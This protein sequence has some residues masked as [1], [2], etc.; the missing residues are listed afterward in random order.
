MDKG[1]HFFNCDFQVH[2]PRDRQWQGA[3]PSTLNEK[4][5][6]AREFVEACRRKGVSAVA[7]ADHHDMSFV[8]LIRE[9][10]KNEN[11]KDG[12][13][14]AEHQ[15]LVVFPGM[16]LT[17]GIPCQALIIF[18]AEL[19]TD[20][21]PLAL[22]A[23]AIT[24]APDD[25]PRTAET[26]RLDD[27]KSLRQLYLLMD[28]H[29]FLR[30]R[31]I[32]LPNV[33]EGGTST[34]LRSGHAG[35]YKEMP[36]VGGYVDGEI[37]QLGDGNRGIIG[38]KNP[39]YGNKKIAVFQ[40]S[41][42]RTRDFAQ[43]GTPTTW[44]KWATPT[45]EALRQ[46]CLAQE[47]RITHTQPYIPPIEI[48]SVQVSNSK[49]LG[50]VVIEFNPQYNAIIGGRGTG[51][52]TILEYL[53]WGLCDEPPADYLEGDNSDY[54]SKRRSLIEK[55]L[56]S[57]GGTVQTS[58][59]LNGVPHIVRRNA[60]TSELLL[61]IG[62]AN[63]TPCKESDVRSLLPIQ[64]YSQKQ[65]SQVGVKLEELNRF[66]RQGMKSEL[67]AL[68]KALSTSVT[69]IRS[70]FSRVLHK[71]QI[72][73]R[74][75]DNQT[76]LRSLEEQVRKLRAGL[77][78]LD[79]AD[80]K[81]ISLQSSYEEADDY[82]SR[83]TGGIG[84]AYQGLSEITIQKPDFAE[85][86][87]TSF[88]D[89]P[90]RKLVVA[91]ADGVQN[92]LRTAH[93]HLSALQFELNRLSDPAD[94]I[95]QSISKWQQAKEAY[96]QRYEASKTKS[97]AQQT[98]LDQLA[99][100]EN[101]LKTLRSEIVTLTS[102]L[103]TIGQP[104]TQYAELRKQWEQ[105]H[106][107]RAQRLESQCQR[108]TNLSDGL[109]KA[110]VKKCAN[111]DNASTKLKSILAGTNIRAPKVESAFEHII[112]SVDPIAEWSS[113]LTELEQLAL[114]SK[115]SNQASS[116]PPT[117]VLNKV[118]FSQADT[119]KISAKLTIDSWLDLSLVVL[120]DQPLFEYRAREADYIPF[121]DASAGQQA[122]ALLW[123]LLSQEGPP[124]VIDQ[125][126]DDLDNQVISKVVEHIWKAKPKRQLIFSSHNA[127]LVVNGDAEL[128][129][130][131]DYRIAGDQ[132][133]GVVKTQGAI[134]V[135]DVREEITK[136]MEGGEEAFK[137]RRDKYGF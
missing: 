127:N 136:V 44:I 29:E 62:D 13:L 77:R 105:L 25:D 110:S 63:Y 94:P 34:L 48:T 18:D 12:N 65:L 46:A 60:A 69:E 86:A 100:L 71:R 6:Y 55:T 52:S 135:T 85:L 134:D 81:I 1:A 38:G 87:S 122:T 54:K 106:R 103:E 114:V 74:L 109:I 82:V 7:I 104:E 98:T 22:T 133:T 41:D 16:E 89:L 51:K 9:A 129:M 120:D 2:S 17:L 53:R 111:F 75:S 115:D 61:K 59:L 118:G 117:P 28:R 26:R 80:Q 35:H 116:L 97:S 76:E 93:R 27:I 49:F 32:V 99:V 68:L 84:Q 56:V 72:Q 8:P 11:D 43:L 58:F 30:G 96:Q 19:P 24:Q 92:I 101:R 102:E 119:Q 33:S 121:A 70:E 50:P 57:L 88:P 128:V 124:L 67:D 123:A 5:E 31:Y 132:S 47:S 10:A 108:L 14:L 90:D 91:V 79:E 131:C 4:R 36:C 83:L 125:P 113:L 23:L 40:T 45:A 15:R 66:V 73:K 3:R 21:F 112:S 64:S 137:L 95:S 107:E 78:G 39:E 130:C 126:E 37:V 20:L 42:T